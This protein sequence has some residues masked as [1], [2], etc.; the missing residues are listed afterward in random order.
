MRTHDDVMVEG[1][2]LP[3]EAPYILQVSRWDQL[4]D[5][6]GVMRAFTDHVVGHDDTHLVLAGPATEGVSDDPEGD[7][8]LQECRDLWRELPPEQ[9]AR[10]HLACVPMDDVDEN[11]YIVPGLGDAGDRLYGVV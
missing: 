5:M 8:V 2:P 9:Q 3:P 4:K 7:H 10:V 1:G 11:A 6:P